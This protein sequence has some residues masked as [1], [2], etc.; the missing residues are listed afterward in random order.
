MKLSKAKLIKL[1]KSELENLGFKEFKD[2]IGG[3]QGLFA[4]KMRNGLYLT[5]GLTIHRYYESAFTADFYLSKTTRIYTIWGDIPKESEERLGYLLTDIERLKYSNDINNSKVKDIWWDGSDEKSVIDFLEVIKLTEPRFVNQPE[6]IEKINLSQDVNTLAKY[7]EKVKYLVA[8]NHLEVNFNFLPTK[9][10]D[11]IP[12]IWFKAA[13]SVLK[14][15]DGILNINGVKLLAA[16]A[17]RQS[18][19]DIL[20]NH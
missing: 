2:S 9:E 19:L 5:L 13:E 15:M 7:S 18:E 11:D 1:V 10:I 17:Y 4:K 20:K 6:L 12:I 14:E 3:T 16:D 8:S